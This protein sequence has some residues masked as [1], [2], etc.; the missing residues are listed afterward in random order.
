MEQHR[1]RVPENRVLRRTFELKRYK[2]KGKLEET[3]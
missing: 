1:L 2:V 3:A